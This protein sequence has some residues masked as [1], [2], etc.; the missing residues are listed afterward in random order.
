MRVANGIPLGCPLPLTGWHCKLRRN[1]E[2]CGT[3]VATLTLP[4]TLPQTLT[5]TLTLTLTL[6]MDSADPLKAW[7]E[8][9]H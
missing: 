3:T 6:T 5:R 8:A 9:L 1:T 7:N 2:G 4:L